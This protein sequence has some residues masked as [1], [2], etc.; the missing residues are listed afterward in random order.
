MFLTT[1][2]MQFRR[3]RIRS[4]KDVVF[5]LA[6]GL[7]A[8]GLQTLL[9]RKYGWEER[10]ARNVAVLL[11]LAAVIILAVISVALGD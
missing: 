10:K 3:V 8:L 11:I 2:A 4:W 5:I 6:A 1:L 9:Q 7:L